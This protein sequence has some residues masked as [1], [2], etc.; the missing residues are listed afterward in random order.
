MADGYRIFS[1]ELKEELTT[2]HNGKQME[3]QGGEESDML[4][5]CFSRFF[6][7]NLNAE[8]R[9]GSVFNDNYC[10]FERKIARSLDR[11]TVCSFRLFSVYVLI[12]SVVCRLR[13][14]G[15]VIGSCGKK[16][17]NF[18]QSN[19]AVS[20]ASLMTNCRRDRSHFWGIKSTDL[21]ATSNVRIVALLVFLH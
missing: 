5:Q 6:S 21:T 3:T 4:K 14:D 7:E 12:S 11:P 8:R 17:S 2:R 19:A 18:G 15:F 9:S 1:F 16:K 10:L 13:V 20:R